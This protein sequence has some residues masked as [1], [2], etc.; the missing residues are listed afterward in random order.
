MFVMLINA[1][2]TH[3]QNALN[4]DVKLEIS[5]AMGNDLQN[6]PL[7]R[8]PLKQKPLDY[9]NYIYGSR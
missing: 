1:T 2:G 8:L 9:Y 5:E 6:F 4:F 7:S 3:V